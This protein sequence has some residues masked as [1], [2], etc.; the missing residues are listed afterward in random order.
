METSIVSEPF[1]VQ[2]KNFDQVKE[3]K[4]T[5]SVEDLLTNSL[6]TAPYMY[7]L[8][9]TW[10]L[11]IGILLCVFEFST[12]FGN[13]IIGLV[14]GFFFRTTIHLLSN[15]EIEKVSMMSMARMLLLLCIAFMMH[16][17]MQRFGPFELIFMGLSIVFVHWVYDFISSKKKSSLPDL[18]YIS[19]FASKFLDVEIINEE[20]RHLQIYFVAYFGALFINWIL[21]LPLSIL[22]C[23]HPLMHISTILVAY[24][25]LMEF[26]PVQKESIENLLKFLDNNINKAFSFVSLK[27]LL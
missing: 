5:W 18:Y 20:V 27:G 16:L 4:S 6:D 21:G 15:V 13:F 23:F 1:D 10:L 7:D 2:K 24:L 14:L 11:H 3:M 26:V 17:D 9:S 25:E 19:A 8:F 12:F 22:W